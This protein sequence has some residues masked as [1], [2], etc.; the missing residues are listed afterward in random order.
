VF[1]TNVV[2]ENCRIHHLL[3]GT[4]Q[5]QQDAHGITGRWGAVTIRNCDIAYT[6]GDSIQFDPDRASQGKILVEDCHL[7]TGPLPAAAAGFLA[8]ERPGE[9]A[10]DTKTRPDGERCQ[11]TVLNCYLHGWNQPAQIGNVAALNLKEN[12]DAEIRNCVFADN[13]IAFRV[14][15]PGSRG[16][17]RV[18]IADCAIYQTNLGLRVEDKVEKLAI[19][20]LAFGEDVASRIRFVNGQPTPGYENRGERNAPPLEAVLKN[21]SWLR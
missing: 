4:F 19:H 15:G 10:I 13:E 20:N 5:D 14:R 3:N 2:I 7:W 8:G 11:L 18:T 9:N 17:A 1:G 12:V 16:G 6:S 21:G